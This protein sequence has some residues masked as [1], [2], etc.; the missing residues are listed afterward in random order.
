MRCLIIDDSSEDRSLVERMLQRFGHR[1]T[2]V[3]SGTAALAVLGDTRFDVA[4]VD[5]D[6]PGMSGAETMRAMREVDARMR[7]LVV[8][9]RDDRR[10]VLEAID[11]GADGYLLKDELGDR[12][13]GALQELFAGKS[14]LSGSVGAVLVR[15]LHH[16]RPSSQPPLDNV[17][18]V[19]PRPTAPPKPEPK[20]REPKTAGNKLADASG[21]LVISDVVLRDRDKD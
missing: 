8:S 9:G 3:S 4:L 10:H 20:P 17:M 6:M 19:T 12:L 16:S 18:R 1:A 2:T 13:G 15:Q 5:L 7:L 11:A 14:P 21:E